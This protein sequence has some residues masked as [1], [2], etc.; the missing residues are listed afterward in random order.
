MSIYTYTYSH[1]H[2]YIYIIYFAEHEKQD[3]CIYTY[4]KIMINLCQK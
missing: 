1:I 2:I 3:I 4:G